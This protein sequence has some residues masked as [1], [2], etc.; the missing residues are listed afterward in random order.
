M[1]LNNKTL[2][3][4]GV[5]G[6]GIINLKSI[7]LGEISSVLID[8]KKYKKFMENL[9]ETKEGKHSYEIKWE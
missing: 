8:G 4:N 5:T 6:K 2:K 1:N 3:L 9:V 7:G